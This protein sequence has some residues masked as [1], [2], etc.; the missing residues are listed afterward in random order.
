MTSSSKKTDDDID[1]TPLFLK[2]IQNESEFLKNYLPL[3]ETITSKKYYSKYQRKFIDI[4][5]T[6]I[7][8]KKIESK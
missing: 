8:D 6:V 7:K 3:M 4:I 5:K 1:F 2:T